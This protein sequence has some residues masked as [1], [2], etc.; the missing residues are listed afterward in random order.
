[1]ALGGLLLR[2]HASGVVAQREVEALI[3]GVGG[4]AALATALLVAGWL[5]ATDVGTVQANGLLVRDSPFQAPLLAAALVLSM[6]LA[7]SAVVSVARERERG[8]LEVV[9]YGPVDEAAY[10][11]GKFAGQ[12]TGYALALP[13]VIASFL[14]LSLFTGFAFTHLVLLGLVASIVPAAEV[15]AF[16]LLLSVAAG[17]LRTAILLFVGVVALFVAI[18]F[19]YNVV[20]A[21]PVGS[22]ASP[23]LPLRDA[24]SALDAAVDWVS[25]FSYLERVLESIALGAWPPAATALLAGMGHVAV[26][27]GL[28]SVGLRRRGVRPK[29]D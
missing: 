11:A 23:I 24:L 12:V 3:R 15:V 2:A 25:P 19:A 16:G 6:F 27:L 13:V 26:A 14:L 21:I 9:F 4:Y 28:A 10:L 5:L 17:R 18:A 20:S 29:G 8:T 7:I 22:P 1:M